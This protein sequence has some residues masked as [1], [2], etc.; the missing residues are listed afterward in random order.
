[1]IIVSKYILV[2]VP[3]D[4]P[5]T[6]KVALRESLQMLGLKFYEGTGKKNRLFGGGWFR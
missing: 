4:L 1:M 2:E 6:T 3:D 5:V